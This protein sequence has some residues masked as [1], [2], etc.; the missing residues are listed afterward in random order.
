MNHDVVADDVIHELFHGVAQNHDVGYAQEVAD[1]ARAG[2]QLD[3]T[4]LLNL[5]LGR[6]P[7][8]DSDSLLHPSAMAFENADSLAVLTSLL[9]QMS[10]DKATFESNLKVLRE[11]VE[12]NEGSTVAGPVLIR[13]NV[14]TTHDLTDPPLEEGWSRP[15]SQSG[16]NIFN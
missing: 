6:L 9:G 8:A 7:V 14:A 1:A 10:I 4:A 3:V 11:A 5:A 15:V 2:Q 12:K 16:S 13:L